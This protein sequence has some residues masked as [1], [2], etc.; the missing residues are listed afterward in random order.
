MFVEFWDIGGSQRYEATRRVFYGDVDGLVL[1]HDL[2]N[3][4]S[5]D[6][7]Q[8]WLGD[9]LGS[10]ATTVADAESMVGRVNPVPT[11]VVGTKT[12]QCLG[13]VPRRSAVADQLSA[14]CIQVQ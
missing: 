3:R 8:Y 2:S 7:L 11:L 13:P 9:V 10:D 12:D 4:K 14:Q 5:H 6:N 1:V